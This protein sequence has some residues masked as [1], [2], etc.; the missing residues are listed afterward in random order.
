VKLQI[1]LDDLN[2]AHRIIRLILEIEEGHLLYIDID[3]CRRL[4]GCLSHQVYWLATDTNLYLN[5]RSHHYPSTKQAALYTLVYRARALCP[6]E[7]VNDGLEFLKF[8]S[9][10]NGYSQK[11]M[12]H[13]CNPPPRTTKP[14]GKHTLV[15]YLLY[16]Q[17][18]YRCVSRLLHKCDTRNVGLLAGKI[19]SYLHPEQGGWFGLDKSENI[20]GA[21]KL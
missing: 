12:W 1:F 2:C 6:T 9:S 4:D 21:F 3:I 11:E 14:S 15:A 18:N 10:D 13:A 5:S 8:V 20:Y 19:S 16:I 17:L 7:S